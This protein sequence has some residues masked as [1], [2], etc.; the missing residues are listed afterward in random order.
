MILL[1][2]IQRVSNKIL[3][4]NHMKKVINGKLYNTE[5]AKKLGYWSNGISRSDFQFCEETLYK[6]RSGQ[7]F[8]HGEGGPMTKYAVSCG[9]N[10]WSGGEH[11]EPINE[12]T[13]R[14]WCEEHLDADEYISIWDEP[15]E[16]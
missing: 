1:Y 12:D 4:G 3:G 16:A 5:S 13:A 11:I 2:Q 10:S 14:K 6:T 7:Y 15:K 9:Q 8:L